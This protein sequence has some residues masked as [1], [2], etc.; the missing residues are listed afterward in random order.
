MSLLISWG[1]VVKDRD[2]TLFLPYESVQMGLS[3]TWTRKWCFKKAAHF[4]D[5]TNNM[6]LVKIEDQRTVVPSATAHS[7]PWGSV[8]N[9]SSLPCSVFYALFDLSNRD[10]KDQEA[11]RNPMQD[12]GDRTSSFYHPW[13]RKECTVLV[14]F[15]RMVDVSWREH[16]RKAQSGTQVTSDQY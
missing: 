9:P 6:K 12:P 10:H 2:I 14:L 5:F 11:K 15:I 13:A 3:L 7:R 1:S 4:R 8:T 16:G